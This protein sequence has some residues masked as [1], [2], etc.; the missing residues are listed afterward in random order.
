MA[1]STQRSS[2]RPAG[3]VLAAAALMAVA[4][5]AEPP[6]PPPAQ[7]APPATPAAA[8]AAPAPAPAAEESCLDCH[9]DPDIAL[10]LKDGKSHSLHVDQEGFRKSVH[11]PK[12]RCGDCHPDETEVPHPEKQFANERSIAIAYYEKCKRCHFASYTKTLDG[13]H[14]SLQAKGRSEAA[15][16]T[17][18]HGAH[19]IG[20]PDEPR[21][22][23]SA[24]CA[25]CHARI[26]DSYRGSVHGKALLETANGDVPVC[27]DCHRAHDIADPRE[28]DW[29][30]RTPELCGSC[31]ANRRLMDRYGLS[32]A[33]LKTYLADFHG[34]AA[35]LQRESDDGGRVAAVCTDC[36][37]VHDI[38][39]TRGPG[40]AAMKQNLGNVC[41]KCHADAKES[42]PQAWLSHYE[43]SASKTPIVWAVKIFYMFMIPFTVGGVILQII[44][45]LWRVVVNR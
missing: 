29:R 19:D 12:L 22:R 14:V 16:C 37:G 15:L 27:T 45:H 10:D 9:S 34:L 35:S 26:Y 32:T 8:P 25:K 20:R 36:H 7:P 17:D 2:M 40:A 4:A 18:C 11:G 13:V 43:P 44:L 33:V 23:I 5:S 31:H 3:A 6:A 38:A 42:F 21:S 24:T 41:R 39:T 30:L 28:R 1:T